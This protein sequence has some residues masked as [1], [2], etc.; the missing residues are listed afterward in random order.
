MRLLQAKGSPGNAPRLPGEAAGAAHAGCH[1]TTALPQTARGSRQVLGTNAA[2]LPSIGNTALPS[3]SSA[4]VPSPGWAQGHPRCIAWVTFGYGGA[5]GD[6]RDGTA[7]VTLCRGGPVAPLWGRAAG[8][9][10]C[11]TP[12]C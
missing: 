6:R 4:V 7:T 9:A 1:G 12:S 5:P 10:V 2:E 3:S 8:T 11:K